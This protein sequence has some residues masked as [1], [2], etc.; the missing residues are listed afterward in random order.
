MENIVLAAATGSRRVMFH[1]GAMLIRV[2][3][4]LEV[5]D[6]GNVARSE[7]DR[8]LTE[9]HTNPGAAIHTAAIV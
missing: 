8:G 4:L 5:L 1:T 9:W 2:R 3:D 7:G 6:T